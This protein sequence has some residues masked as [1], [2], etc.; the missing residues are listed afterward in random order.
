M[1]PPQTQSLSTHLLLPP[2]IL[3]PATTKGR[4]SSSSSHFNLSKKSKSGRGVKLFQP[5][6]PAALKLR[7]AVSLE[8]TIR[9]NNGGGSSSNCKPLP[10][11]V[12]RTI[13]ELSSVGTLSVLT[14]EGFPLG[15]GVR[16]AVDPQGTP[17]LCFNPSTT[18]FVAAPLPTKSTLHV[19]VPFSQLSSSKP[20]T[21][22]HFYR[23][24]EIKYVLYFLNPVRA[25]W[26]AYPTVHHSRHP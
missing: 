14:Q 17:L 19:Q 1:I 10:A 12:S 25:V 24:I 8:P 11:E 20:T 3:L 15:F 4:R 13:M 5:P 9:K 2:S 16:F 7:C 6:P 22:L 21:L 18:N 26:I 23:L